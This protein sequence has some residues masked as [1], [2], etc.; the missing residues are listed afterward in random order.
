MKPPTAGS[1]KWGFTRWLYYAQDIWGSVSPPRQ[2]YVTQNGYEERVILVAGGS[3]NDVRWPAIDNLGRLAYHTCRGRW[4]D[5]QSI[6]YLNPAATRMRI[7]MA[8]MM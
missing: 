2:S 1:R 6:Y 7:R 5:P 3:T 4:F 8:P